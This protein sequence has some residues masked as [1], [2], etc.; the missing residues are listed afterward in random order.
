MSGRGGVKCRD[1][2]VKSGKGGVK[3]KRVK[4]QAEMESKMNHYLKLSDLPPH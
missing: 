3:I 1:K 4:C 2:V